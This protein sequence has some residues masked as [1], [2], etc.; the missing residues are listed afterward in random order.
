MNKKAA[1]IICFLLLLGLLRTG[2]A[3]G[4][5]SETSYLLQH[6]M[7]S[8]S[9]YS[10]EKRQ[11]MVEYKMKVLEIKQGLKRRHINS[12]SKTMQTYDNSVGCSEPCETNLSQ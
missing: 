6:K 11:K 2:M 5:N 10:E 9:P 12:S 4:A 3:Q 8:S 7:D 1:M